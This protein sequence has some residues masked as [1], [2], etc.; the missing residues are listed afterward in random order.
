MLWLG[1]SG[2][3]CGGAIESGGLWD[4]GNFGGE[5][6][7]GIT[8]VTSEIKWYSSLTMP[9]PARTPRL[10]WAASVS[11]LGRRA[12]PDSAQYNASGEKYL[13]FQLK[14]DGDWA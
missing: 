11:S 4:R 12:G 2:R 6:K 13:Y 14:A 8:R 3:R 1:R 5:G 9:S 7:V 10:S